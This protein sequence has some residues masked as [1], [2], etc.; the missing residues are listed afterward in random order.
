MPGVRIH[1]LA[2]AAIFALALVACGN[3][4]DEADDHAAH[5]DDPADYDIDDQPDAAAVWVS[6]LDNDVVSSPVEV[7]MGAT[8]VD[9]VPAGASA[10]G[11]GHLHIL[12]DSGCASRGEVIPGPSDEAE[13]DGYIHFGD[14][15]TSG[16]IDLEPGDYE[17]CLQLADG[18]H[19]A[20]GTTDVIEIRVE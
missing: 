8:D 4:D 15:E 5:E 2:W 13:A 10:V 9:I 16:E 3:A 20:F 12:V 6:P 11:E 17:L 7:E 14:G 1:T 18:A 19:R